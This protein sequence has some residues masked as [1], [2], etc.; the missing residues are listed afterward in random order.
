M[1]Y[2]FY[3]L[4]PIDSGWDLLPTFEEFKIIVQPQ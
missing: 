3:E 2:Y 1:H 4:S